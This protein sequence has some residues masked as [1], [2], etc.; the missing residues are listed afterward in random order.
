MTTMSLPDAHA[1]ERAL[2]PRQSFI[3]QAPAGS[4]KT[5]LLTQRYLVLLSHVNQPE[6]ILAITFTKKSA[7][8]MRARIINTLVKTAESPIEPELEHAKKTWHLAKKVLARD[9]Q[10]K[11][12]LLDNPNRLR[13]QTIDSFNVG[14]TKHLPILSQFGS[15]PEITDR[16]LLLYQAAT[17]DLLSYVDEETPWS[18][19]FSQLL[20]HMDNNPDKLQ[21]LLIT[22]LSKR[23]QWRNH[24]QPNVDADA[25]R[26]DL[27][28]SL[29]NIICDTLSHLCTVFPEKHS[30]ELV[31]LI[32]YAAN[33]LNADQSKSKIIT[34]ANLT[35]LPGNTIHDLP[36]W[37]GIAEL[38][39]T[40]DDDWRKKHTV[41]EGFPA[42]KEPPYYKDRMT[43]LMG[44]FSDNDNLRHAL[45]D[46]K[47]LPTS[48]YDEKQ[49]KILQAL[50]TVL[51][52]TLAELRLAFQKYG[53]IDYIENAIAA[54]HALGSDD[55]PTDI[56]LAMDYRI[57]HILVDEFQD[58]ANLQYHLLQK[59]TAGWGPHDERTLFVVGD[60]MQS[61]YRFREA[62]VGLFI[63]ARKNGLGN[64]KLE[65]LT[66]SVN[67]RSTAAIVNWVN[68]SFQKVLPHYENIATGAVSYSSSIA[69]KTTHSPDSSVELHSFI[70]GDALTEQASKIVELISQAKSKNPNGSIAI[71]VRTRTHLKAIIPALKAAQHAY[72]AI[73]IDPL[74]LRPTIQDL[75]ALTRAL[76][77]PADRIAWLA[78][79]RAPWCGLTLNDLL[80]LTG[81]DKNI[82]LW[83]RLQSPEILST[84]STDGQE[85]LH[86]I[87]PILKEKIAERRRQT[88]RSWI[89]STWILIGGPAC[90]EQ[91]SDLK[92]AAVYFD[93]LEQLD[94]GGSLSHL[95]TLYDSVK[96]LFAAPD[97]QADEN[98]QI[99]TI[100]NAKGLEFDTVILPHL[101]KK[102]SGDDKQLLLWLERTRDNS[103]SDLIIA[104]VH[105]VGE[106][107]DSI[108]DY[109]KRQM[110]IKASYE[111][112]RLLY[113]AA[114][115]A[116]EKLHILF[117]LE[118]KKTKNKSDLKPPANSLLDKLW[119]AINL[120]AI[121][122]QTSNS[123]ISMI[124]GVEN[125]K[126]S[127]K[128]LT[129]NWVNPI[130]K[131]NIQLIAYHQQSNGF[132]P[133][134]NKPRLIGTLMHQILQHIS[135]YGL[136]WWNN[137]TSSQ[138]KEY[139]KIQLTQAG[140]IQCE[141]ES[142]I[143]SIVIGIENINHDPKAAW[144]LKSH[145]AAQSEFPL[146]AVI[147]KE[148]KS[149]VI[150]RTFIDD[151][152]VRW[153]IDYKTSIFNADDLDNFLNQEQE[154]YKK[155]LWQYHQALRLMENRP[156]RVGL[157]F[158]MIPAWR[159]WSFE[160][161]SLLSEF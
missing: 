40:G 53:K 6:E 76:L 148:I 91:E 74:S 5:E 8:E 152:D 104:P 4:G 110:K 115:R 123:S 92:D 19:A 35:K 7:R 15:A 99:M 77:Y 111:D 32:R 24:I 97:N 87:L 54:L 70:D 160:T 52:I 18:E 141:L 17:Q 155:Q 144:I 59:L 84:L 158:P 58:T 13:I 105:G 90:V 157:Y 36:L 147:D 39:L 75:M 112:G 154:K 129:S 120:D 113:V 51:H 153:I 20:L 60:P 63:Y 2:D 156:I 96:L 79:L 71:L 11:W 125:H 101:E 136:A 55:E 159:E 83:Q 27:E 61:I 114:T 117:S 1:R 23:D 45:A 10:L 25:L 31:T 116:K 88:L 100:H 124:V 49:W 126:N 47:A 29:K 103:Q 21:T 143:N 67:F 22:M 57:Q 134:Q 106:K 102:P 33:N 127:F 139:I 119:P 48:E 65:P 122:T 72:R 93:L 69:I 62:E 66:L 68:E 145:T 14:I 135:K 107:N 34:C 108:Y 64:I 85:R 46:V 118:S 50:N 89:E 131:S 37:L 56:A 73:K 142:A 161:L 28:Q 82:Q 38:L 3:V 128:R 9:S 26:N 151:E 138:K 44:V 109:I 149:F 121:S 78:I 130:Q 30:E 137:K 94:D 16:Q 140:L 80:L 86:R 95:D 43:E 98:L 146:T 150:D 41:R 42:T 81:N 12:N 132:L 133:I